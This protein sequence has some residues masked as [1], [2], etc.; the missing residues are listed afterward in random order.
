[1]WRIWHVDST[2][3]RLLDGTRACT[4]R[5]DRQ[6]LATDLGVA[7]LGNDSATPKPRS[8]ARPFRASKVALES[9]AFSYHEHVAG[10]FRVATND[11][12]GAATKR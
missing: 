9:I 7:G 11:P 8:I 1:M 10:S 6:L 3:M 5:G 4:V 12:D 2:V